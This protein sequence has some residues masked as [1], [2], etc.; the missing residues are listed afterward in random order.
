MKALS[1]KQP[2][3]GLIIAGIKRVENRTWDTKYEGKL[4]I[5]ATATPDNAQAWNKARNMC[6]KQGVDFPEAL[7]SV[8]G[9][10]L[11]VVDFN[12][13]IWTSGEDGQP[14]TDHPT[15]TPDE[16]GEWWN[17]DCVGFIMDNPQA[18]QTAIPLKGQLGLYKIA[19]SIEDEIMN[20]LPSMS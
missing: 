6:K 7:C 17:P 10:I 20:L 4:A 13:L 5:V 12:H 3:A 11:G 14:E 15:I 16:V 8:N 18:L 1:I 9:A 19:K 2:Y